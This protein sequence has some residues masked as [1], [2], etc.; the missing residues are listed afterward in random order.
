MRLSLTVTLGTSIEE[1][2]SG[3][4]TFAEELFKGAS[5]KFHATYSEAIE[6]ILEKAGLLRLIPQDL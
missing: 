6:D 3:N 5:V 4:E 1:I 2:M